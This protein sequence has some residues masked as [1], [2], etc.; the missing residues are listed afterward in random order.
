[1]QEAVRRGDR[2]AA[3]GQLAAGLAHELRNPLA[4]MSGAVELLSRGRGLS[5]AERKLMEIVMREAERLNALVTDFL[6]FARPTTTQLQPTD[7][8]ALAD[9]TLGVFR[10]SPNAAKIE[11]LR[12]GVTSLRIM[13]DAAQLRQ[14]LWNLLQN[15]A[16]AMDGEGDITVDVGLTPE[17]LCRIAV[18]DSGHG[19]PPA[20]IEH[21][22]EPFFTTKPHGTGLGLAFV[23]RIVEAHGGHVDV[24][25]GV[26]RG[27]TF[28]VL[29][30]PGIE[31]EDEEAGED[32][33]I[34]VATGGT[35]V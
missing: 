34:A 1:M 6:A 13:A 12:S 5:D 21:L 20:D 9:E 24:Q 25:S 16:E 32:S 14:V 26:G 27:A 29:L 7:V 8:A 15:A 11:L 31:L 18:A 17:G 23:H 30:T 28:S 10:H 33:P 3:V 22:F 19:I 4:S 35:R 2:L